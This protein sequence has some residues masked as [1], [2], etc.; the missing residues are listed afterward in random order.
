MFFRSKYIPLNEFFP[1]DHVDFHSHLL[2]GID[3][4]AKTIEDSVVLIKKMVNNGVRNFITT[5]HI[6]GSVWPNTP[7]IINEKLKLV[8]TR[9][10]EEGIDVQ[11]RAAAEYMMDE[12][13]VGF[14]QNRNL[15][16][17]KENYLLVEMSYLSPPFNLFEM[18]YEIQ[19]AGYEP[20]LAHPERYGFYHQDIKKYKKLKDHG[21]Q[22]QLN[23]LSLTQHYGKSVNKTAIKLLKEGMIDFVGTDLH[24][25]G[26]LGLME[27]VATKNNL[28]LLKGALERN[29]LFK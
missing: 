4:G 2:P 22:F 5:P 14:L 28:K 21:C 9:L 19:T 24:H 10:H 27:K 18:I 29:Q 23:L 11:L 8:H 17:L 25:S 16:P 13:F 7:E 12:K 20:V 3:D 26:H 6:L 1:P 15:L